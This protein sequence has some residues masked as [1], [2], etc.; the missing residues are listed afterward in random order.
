MLTIYFSGTGNTEY[1]AKLF[2]KKMSATCLS[3]EEDVDFHE[4][5]QVNDTICFCYPIYGSRV[6]A[7]MRRFVA[8]HGKI[9]KGKKLIVLVTQALFSGDGAR[10]FTD[11]FPAEYMEVV[12]TEHFMMPNNICNFFLLKQESNKKIEKILKRA[13]ARVEGVCQNIKN[14]KRRRRGYSGFS[15]FLGGFQGIPWQGKSSCLKVNP[16]SMEGRAAKSVQIDCDCTACGLCI[17]IC[18]M[19]NLTLKDD[20]VIPRNRCIACYRCVNRCPHRAITT[21]IKGKPKW[22][23][24]GVSQ[25]AKN[26]NL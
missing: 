7:I 1:I 8:R 19:K 4:K 11:M 10:V 25:Y 18:P 21:F 3:I 12:Y 15:K 26:N 24:K 5:I 14:N 9:L 16:Y 17:K 2:S 6:P 22:K 20:K 23:Y 13:E